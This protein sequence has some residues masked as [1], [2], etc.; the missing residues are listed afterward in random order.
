MEIYGSSTP[1]YHY[2]TQLK[3]A[4]PIDLIFA[5]K[6]V[7]IRQKCIFFKLCQYY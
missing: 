3:M 4:F 5:L 2:D 6:Y 1:I 7:N